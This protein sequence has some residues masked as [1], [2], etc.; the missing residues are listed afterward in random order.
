MKDFD[1]HLKAGY[2]SLERC[3]STLRFAIMRRA[4]SGSA[5]RKYNRLLDRYIP[6]EQR[7]EAGRA[8]R[9]R[10]PREKHAGWTAPKDRPDPIDLLIKSNETRLANLVPIRYGR[11][12]TSAFAFL[13][14]RRT[15]R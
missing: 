9:E 3:R 8:L 4:K 10:V 12:L 14:S 15:A 13:R 2:K 11:M 7:W 5:P 6:W 1:F